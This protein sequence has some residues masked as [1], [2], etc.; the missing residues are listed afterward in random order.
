M[1]MPLMLLISINTE[2]GYENVAAK[3]FF[4]C[5]FVVIEWHRQQQ[6]SF[7]AW[8]RGTK[9][10]HVLAMSMHEFFFWARARAS[11]MFRWNRKVKSFA[12]LCNDLSTASDPLRAKT[13]LNALNAFNIVPFGSAACKWRKSQREKLLIVHAAFATSKARVIS[14]MALRRAFPFAPCDKTCLFPRRNCI[15]TDF[16]RGN[17]EINT[18]Y[19]RQRPKQ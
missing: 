14:P 4:F 19:H 6:N 8:A 9:R 16:G 13:G 11:G 12:I 5:R 15:R 18:K 3:S 7:T 10:I 17:W 2:V 1:T